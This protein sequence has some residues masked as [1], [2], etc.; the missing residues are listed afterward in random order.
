VR[1]G[2]RAAV[3]LAIVIGAFGVSFGV[4]AT[5]SGFGGLA[6]IA[7]S[8]STFSGAS[9]FAA[10]SI[11][12]TGGGVGAAVLAAVL[13]AARYGPIGLT[14]APVI[15]GPAVLRFLQAQLIIDESWA[16]SNRGGGRYD[17]S[18]LIG[19][20]ALMCLAWIV[21]TIAGAVGGDFLGD[22]ETFGLDAAFPA[23]F[24]GLLVSQLR[25]RTGVVAAVLG[26]AIAF[27]LIPV[28]RPGIPIIMA[29]LACIVG[30]RRV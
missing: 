19:A 25:D 12:A 27:A 22:P 16:V 3:P 9:Q 10:I 24:L 6:A 7:M 20:G 21:G 4:L 29:A 14:V 30:L 23:L 15:R 26:A 8:M 5:S 11:L 28:A 17:R 13:L 2:V 1:Q 18:I